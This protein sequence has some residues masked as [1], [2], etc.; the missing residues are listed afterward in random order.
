MDAAKA[1]GITFRD[2]AQ[3]IEAVVGTGLASDKKEATR[4][5]CWQRRGRAFGLALGGAR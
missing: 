2:E 3:F 4:E 5:P 1:K